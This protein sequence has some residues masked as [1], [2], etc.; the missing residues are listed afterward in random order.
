M[1]RKGGKPADPMRGSSEGQTLR[2]APLVVIVTSLYYA[3]GGQV[4][5]CLS[6]R[7]VTRGGQSCGAGAVWCL[8]PTRTA[9]AYIASPSKQHPNILSREMSGQECGMGAPKNSQAA[10]GVVTREKEFRRSLATSRQR[11]WVRVRWSCRSVCPSL[12]R[13]FDVQLSVTVG[14]IVITV[15]LHTAMKAQKTCTRSI[16]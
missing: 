16:T 15:A 7:Q 2:A 10:G 6:A 13:A 3:G 1:P 8:A 9:D 4:E 14:P 12:D 5:V 11:I